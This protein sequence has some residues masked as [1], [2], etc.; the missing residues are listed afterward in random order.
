MN[1]KII[2]VLIAL[3]LAAC[4]GSGSGRGS[5][6]GTPDPDPG[7]GGTAEDTAQLRVL[8]NRPDMVSA[9]DVLVEVVLENAAAVEG[10]VL[11]RNGSDVTSVLQATPDNPLRLVGVVDGLAVGDNTLSTNVGNDLTVVNHPSGG[12][13]F[14]G[15][16]IQPWECQDTAADEDCNQQVEY[17]WLYKSSNPLNGG[18]LPYDPEAPPDDV[19]MTT[20]DTGETLPFIVR[21]EIGYQARDQYTIFTLQ[22]VGEDWTPVQPQSQWNGRLLVTHGG[23]CRGDHDTSSPKT[24]D[25]SGT[26]P[27]NPLIDQSYI[28]ALSMGWSVLSTA[29]LNLGHNCNLSYQAESLMMAKERFIEQYGE[30]RYTVGTGCSGGAITQ[31]M[32]ANAYPGLYQGLLTTCTYPDVMSTATQFADY[33]IL[34]RYFKTNMNDPALLARDGT[35][36]TVLQQNEVY[37]HLNGIVNASVADSA[38]FAEA[39]D[40]ASSCGGISDEERFDQDTNPGGARCDVLTFM[41]NMIGQREQFPA[42]DQLRDHWSQIEKDLGY[43]FSGFPLGNEG[44]QYGLIPLQQGL[45]TPDQFLKLNTNIGGLD[46]SLNVTAERLKPDYPAL[47]NAYRTGILNTVVNMD[48]VPIINMTGPDPGIAHDSVHGYWVRWRLEREFGNRDNF[49]HWGGLTPLIGDLTYMSQSLIAMAS[50]LDTIEAD[51]SDAPLAQKIVTNKPASVQDQCSGVPGQMCP[52]ELMLVFGTPRTQ[53]GADKYGDQVQC[54]LKPFSR[55][56]DYGLGNLV[57]QEADWQKL[58]QTFATG[59]CDW[60]KKP[61]AWQPT[62]PWLKYQ[63]DLGEVIIGGE[64]MTPAD[65][66]AGWASPAFSK[67]WVPGW[68]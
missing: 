14:T 2:T 27:G 35:L 26:I 29:Q 39:V 50:W 42:E 15:P 67:T 32:I 64:Q 6:A 37:G 44:V 25:Y 21:Q 41:Q 62:I 36:F 53:A 13:V 47:P 12:P 51:T 63:D 46:P 23:N 3:T 5:S 34:L 66:P 40:P 7:S 57:W 28:T 45:L 54:Q 59:V 56:D 48:T 24:D 61:L 11:T 55:A 20:T 30:L 4:G 19:A 33:H 9:G 31:N 49:V 52:D 58:E 22:K 60:S 38:L 43:A 65:F 18:L 16:H 8:S 68:Q 10:L 1:V 17:K